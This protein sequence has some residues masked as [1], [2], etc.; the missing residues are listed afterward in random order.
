MKLI[1][2]LPPRIS[3]G[4]RPPAHTDK[5]EM[6]RNHPEKWGLITIA[7]SPKTAASQAHNI[8]TGQLR[9]FVPAG[10]FEAAARGCEVYARYAPKDTE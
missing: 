5:A 9:A 6:L 2:A 3:T 4:G 8:R 7:A 10:E 1:D